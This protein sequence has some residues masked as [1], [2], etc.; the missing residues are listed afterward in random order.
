MAATTETVGEQSPDASNA[1]TQAATPPTT[2]DVQAEINK[3]LTAQQKAFQ[4]QLKATTGF[5]SLD[6]FKEN[7]LKADGKLQEL[8]EA[9]AAKAQSYQ[10]K[11]QQS[12]INNALLSASGEAVDPTLVSQLLAGRCQCDDD[13]NVTID[14]KP[15]ADAVKSL[16][17]DK[18][19]LAKAQGGTGS[20]SPQQTN[21]G[22]KTMQRQA[23]DKL[24]ATDKA[25]FVKAGGTVFN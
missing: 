8:A 4:E 11:F 22:A 25:A 1:S 2:V 3:A 19:F 5:D 16:L 13:G 15:V 14:G 23:F 9:N 12:A 7:K 20:G 10:A 21:A 18:P 24:S 17:A 6:A